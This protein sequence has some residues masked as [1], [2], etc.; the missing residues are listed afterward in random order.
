VQVIVL[1]KPVAIAAD[2]FCDR[3]ALDEELDD[4]AGPDRRLVPSGQC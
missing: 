2:G 4:V 3:A 1:E